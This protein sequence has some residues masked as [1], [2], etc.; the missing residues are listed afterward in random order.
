MSKLDQVLGFAV[1][2]ISVTA[3]ALAM[4]ATE[5]WVHLFFVL[6]LGLLAWRGVRA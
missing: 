5:R 1:L 4:I 3:L 6:C 2:A